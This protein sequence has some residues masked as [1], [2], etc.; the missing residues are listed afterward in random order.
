[1]KKIRRLLV[2]LSCAVSLAACVPTKQLPGKK[3][4]Y[5]TPANRP[6]YFVNPRHP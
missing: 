4:Y 5:K 1:M 2:L 6:A 3:V